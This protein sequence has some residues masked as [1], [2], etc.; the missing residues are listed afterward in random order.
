L[1]VIASRPGFTFAQLIAEESDPGPELLVLVTGAQNVCATDAVEVAKSFAGFVSIAVV[2]AVAV[3][4]IVEP[5]APVNV[6]ARAIV[7]VPGEPIVPSEQLTVPGL[8]GA[9]AV[10]EPWLG[11]TET[12][13]VPG[14]KGSFTVTSVAASGPPLFTVIV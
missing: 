3:F 4:A 9:G 1:N 7:A 8:P 12:K 2:D 10:H 6:T 11:V 14:G 13:V 5:G